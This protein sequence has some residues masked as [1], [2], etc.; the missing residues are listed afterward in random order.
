[1]SLLTTVRA[2]GKTYALARAGEASHA[3]EKV[4]FSDLASVTSWVE[5]LVQ[6]DP[7]GSAQLRRAVERTTPRSVSLKDGD[8]L[9]REAA[10]Q[11]WAQLIDVMLM[12]WWTSGCAIRTTPPLTLSGVSWG[13]TAS[14]Y[15]HEHDLYKPSKWEVDKVCPLLRARAAI[16]DIAK[17]NPRVRKSSRMKDDIEK[18]MLPYHAVENFPKLDSEI[19]A[20]VKWFY[21]SADPSGPVSHPGTTGTETV[22]VY[23]PFWNVGGG[24]VPRGLAWVRCYRSGQ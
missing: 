6:E 13:E 19:T 14:L 3:G 24:D 18:M 20:E 2:R 1:M 7:L 22:K 5:R 8:A 12:R 4:R 16:H 21:L 10:L 15:P 17:R 11:I 9:T 23:G